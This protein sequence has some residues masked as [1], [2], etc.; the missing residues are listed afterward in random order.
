MNVF[1]AEPPDGRRLEIAEDVP[2]FGSFLRLKVQEPREPRRV[3]A[4][5]CSPKPG[6]AAMLVSWSVKEGRAVHEEIPV[7]AVAERPPMTVR[8]KFPANATALP[9]WG[10]S[11]THGLDQLEDVRTSFLHF[12]PL[13]EVLQRLDDPLVAEVHQLL[14]R[15]RVWRR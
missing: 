7:H 1:E 10:Q 15:P 6:P 12:V 4:L 14:D 11:L 9:L 3:G 8:R 13:G 5:V 2:I